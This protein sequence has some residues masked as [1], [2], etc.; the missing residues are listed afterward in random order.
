MSAIPEELAK[1]TARLSEEATRPFPN[2][3][4]I[5]VQGSRPDLKVG[6]REIAQSPTPAA[7]G[8]EDN[9]PIPVYDT[10]GPYGEPGA[11]I[12]LMRGLLP[13]RQ[14]WIEGRGDT[15]ALDEFTSEYAAWRKNDP[16]LAHLRFA[17]IRLPRRARTSPRCTTPARA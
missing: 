13:L 12:D 4:K 7:G 11:G 16:E 9:P 6:M 8:A 15:E 10:S 14:G 1:K 2:S 3:K 17:H 5:Y